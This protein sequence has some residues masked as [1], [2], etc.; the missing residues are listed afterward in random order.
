VLAGPHNCRATWHDNS[1]A[2]ASIHLSSLV[3]SL[4]PRLIGAATST[5]T[6]KVYSKITVEKLVGML[7]LIIKLRRILSPLRIIQSLLAMEIYFLLTNSRKS[8]AFLK[9]DKANVCKIMAT[10]NL[11]NSSIPSAY[12]HY[13]NGTYAYWEYKR[14]QIYLFFY[15]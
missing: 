2:S 14:Q 9:Y 3:A 1:A 8:E 10:Q 15:I 13:G 4:S 5:S 12:R 6:A 7:K 11:L